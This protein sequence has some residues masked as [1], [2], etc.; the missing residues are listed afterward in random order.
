MGTQQWAGRLDNLETSLPP[1]GRVLM[2]HQSVVGRDRPRALHPLPG[3]PVPPDVV[4]A[5]AA[6]P[7]LTGASN[8]VLD[9]LGY[10]L[11]VPGTELRPLR[12]GDVL[13]GRALTLRYLP[14]R[15]RPGAGKLAH[16]SAAELAR[17][18]DV[19]VISAPASIQVSVLGGEAARLLANA[20]IAGVVA[21]GYIRDLDE[22]AATDLRVWYRGP[23]PTSGRGHLEVGEINGV[24]EIGGIAVEPGDIVVADR[25]GVTFVPPAAFESLLTR[26]LGVSS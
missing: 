15:H 4:V 5:L 20:G 26:V 23:T 14:S 7:G 2:E 11:A 12:E 22:V 8:D 18:G 21:D 6:V 16:L 24:V 1:G 17:P 13:I 25:S 10:R 19:L 3:N 9:E